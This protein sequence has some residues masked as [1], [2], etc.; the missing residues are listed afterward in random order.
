[1]IVID[2][3][4]ALTDHQLN[5]AKSV[6]KFIL[7]SLS[8]KDKVG[9]VDLTSTVQFPSSETCSSNLELAFANY[10]TKHLYGRYIDELQRSHNSTNHYLGF[11]KAFEIIAKNYASF[12]SEIHSTPDIFI[13]Y[14]SRGFLASIT[15]ALPV[16]ELIAAELRNSSYNFVIN[17]YALIDESKPIMYETTFLKEIAAMNFKRFNV[18]SPNL[19]KIRVSSKFF[20]FQQMTFKL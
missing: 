15:D 4:S 14:I 6:A 13:P 11:K 19:D 18:Q 20:D 10:E 1:M 7:N 2:R 9:I 3:G 8:H 5:I 17:T 16:M 12:K